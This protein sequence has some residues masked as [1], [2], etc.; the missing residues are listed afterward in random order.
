MVT[1]LFF[2]VFAFLMSVA[3]LVFLKSKSGQK[4]LREL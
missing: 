3:F 4:W 1:Y 2:N